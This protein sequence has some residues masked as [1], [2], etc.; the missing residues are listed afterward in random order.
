M[1]IIEFLGQQNRETLVFWHSLAT[2][3]SPDPEPPL[4]PVPD[5][6]IKR[7]LVGDERQQIVV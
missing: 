1:F 4:T 2:M 7:E 5:K 3:D 6:K